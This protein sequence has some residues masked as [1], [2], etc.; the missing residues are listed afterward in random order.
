MAPP[1]KIKL[2]LFKI[3]GINLH[4]LPA[5]WRGVFCIEKPIFDKI[6]H[7]RRLYEK[8]GGTALD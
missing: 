3:Y 8:I 2:T 7:N 1:A 4:K 5:R 6:Y